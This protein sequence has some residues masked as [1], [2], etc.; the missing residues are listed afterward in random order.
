MPVG[1]MELGRSDR[2]IGDAR[3]RTQIRRFWVSW[4]PLYDALG[5]TCLVCTQIR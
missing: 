4:V 2:R 5:R 1:G 3:R